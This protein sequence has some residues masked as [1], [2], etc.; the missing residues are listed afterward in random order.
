M[1]INLDYFIKP[2][3]V[4]KNIGKQFHNAENIICYELALLH[5]AYKLQEINILQ[6]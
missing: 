2:N 1:G 6:I 5:L 3:S 4:N